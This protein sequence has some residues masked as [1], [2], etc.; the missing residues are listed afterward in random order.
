MKK[1]SKGGLSSILTYLFLLFI[2]W[3]E[4][5]SYFGGYIDEQYEVDRSVRE[6]AQIN[7]DMFIHIPCQ[8][9]HVHVRDVT[10][11]TQMASEQLSFEDIPFF[12]PYGT[13]VNDKNS[14]VTPEL[15][16]ILAEAIPAQFRDRIAYDEST[17]S[18]EY[19]GCH[20]FGSIPVTR[21]KG[22]LQ[23]T[24]KGYGYRDAVS[25]PRDI[26][27][28]SHVINEFSFGDFF[29][30]IDNT[31]DNTAKLTEESLH[32]YNYFT[33]VV[34]TVYKKMGAEVDTNQYS[35]SEAEYTYS[36]DNK[37]APGIFVKYN[38]E[39]L[40]IVM[41]DERINFLQF[42]IR[43]VAIMAF[44]VY[45]ASWAFRFVD[46]LLVL[47]LGSKWSLRY[48]SDSTQSHGLLE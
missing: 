28:F 25:T 33:S 15:D 9:L 12:I 44:V 38:F 3:S 48:Q 7:M 8:W 27:N 31:L 20:V 5:G 30:Y 45:M 43:L 24:A 14:I 36:D 32:A 1:S 34:P 19:D 22:E 10:K 6:T 17:G 41:K 11:D 37:G 18:Q 2:A 16:E 21:V 4:F 39:A 26:I 29:P 40:S 46:K 35:L 42:V 23:I 13:K 47:T